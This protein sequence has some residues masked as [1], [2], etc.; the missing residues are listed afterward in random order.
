MDAMGN[1]LELGTI[2]VDPRVIPLG[3]TVY[4]TGY[5]HN[6]LPVK[7]MTFKATDTGG[8][9]KGN[10]IDIFLPGSN[11]QISSFGIQNVKI[12]VL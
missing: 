2:A 7:G 3:S 9:I 10:R 4:V 5:N 11:D 12:Y 6:G 1:K 8:A